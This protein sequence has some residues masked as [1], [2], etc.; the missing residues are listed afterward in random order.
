MAVK[1]EEKTQLTIEWPTDTP[2]PDPRQFS[3]PNEFAHHVCDNCGLSHKQ[4]AGAIE[5]SP[6]LLTQKLHGNTASLSS[7]EYLRIARALIRLGKEKWGRLMFQYFALQL[8]PPPGYKEKL[9]SERKTLQARIERIN[10]E[11]DR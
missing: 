9:R 10:E 7:D 4:I 3:S 6:S 11:L 5:M 8:L 2:L 1:P